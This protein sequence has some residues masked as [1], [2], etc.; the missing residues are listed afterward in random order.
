[1]KKAI[2][3]LGIMAGAMSAPALAQVSAS[4]VY[5]GVGIGQSKAKDWCNGIAGTGIS[6]DDSDTA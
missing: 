3:A 4:N 1:M 2:V 5:V 6:C